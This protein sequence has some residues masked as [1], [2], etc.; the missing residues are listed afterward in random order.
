MLLQITSS[1]QQMEE[2]LRGTL[3][4]VQQQQLC[5]DRSLWDTMQRCVD[6]LKEK[7]LITIT[8]TDSL[9]LTLQ[10]TRLGRATYKGSVDLT[11]CDL[12]YKDLSKGLEGLLLNSY[13]HLVYLVTPYDL[14]PQCNPDWMVY[15]RQ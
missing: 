7:D 14:I 12:V 11:Y 1:L 4:F 9:S 13:L 5:V 2:F 6:M 8:G 10:I 15:F 3:L